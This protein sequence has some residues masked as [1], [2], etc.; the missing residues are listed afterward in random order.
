MADRSPLAAHLDALMSK[1]S[2]DDARL[3]LGPHVDL[4]SVRARGS[5]VQRVAKALGQETLPPPNACRATL[6]GDCFW[7]RPDEWLV[8]APPA[9]AEAAMTTLEPHLLDDGAVIDVSGSRII[10]ELTGHRT[11]DVLSS[12]CPL[13]LHP[14]VFEPGRCAQSIIGK[15]SVLLHLV[16][17]TPRW[18]LFVHPSYV[19]YVVRWLADGIEGARA[20][21]EISPAAL[22]QRSSRKTKSR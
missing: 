10:L 12:C 4:L 11:R 18:H 13:D 2:F 14:S 19:D 3:T 7:L 22:P 8:A 6:L 16:D 5:A 17:D 9:S 20:E 21:R 15:V 1:A